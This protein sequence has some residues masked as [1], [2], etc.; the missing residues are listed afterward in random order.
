MTERSSTRSGLKNWDTINTQM[1]GAE[2]KR[3]IRVH[4]RWVSM[5]KFVSFSRERL[6]IHASVQLAR[7]YK[8]L[9]THS[10]TRVI[11]SIFGEVHLHYLCLTVR[12]MRSL[13]S[14]LHNIIG[15]ARARNRS[16]VVAPLKR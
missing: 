5:A 11:V 12:G 14:S 6:C 1:P 13:V 7:Q 15:G 4:I 2:P 3:M 10:T 16:G 8:P 9:T